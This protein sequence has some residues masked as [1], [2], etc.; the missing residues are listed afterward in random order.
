MRKEK[1]EELKSYVEELKT[2][3][4]SKVDGVGRFLGVEKYKCQLNN[5]KVI[6]RE[7]IIKDGKDGNAC[8]ILPITEEGNTLL[9]VQP[10][11]F[12]NQTV[13]V[14]LP[15]GYVEDGE[16]PMIAAARELAEE[17]GYVPKDMQLLVQYYQDQGCMGAFNR[18]YIALGCR[19]EK[20][21]QLDKNEFIRYYE[22]TYE[23][24]LELVEMGYINDA[25]SLLTLEKSKDVVKQKVFGKI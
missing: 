15:A 19:K 9:V 24:A 12:T 14:E 16:E 2:I 11:V 5:G 6:P 10:R 13:G 17:T 21:Q 7:K 22:C 23:E 3:Q 4:M 25:G 18:A 20:E 1:L 8:V